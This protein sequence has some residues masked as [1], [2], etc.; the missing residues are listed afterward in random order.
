MKNKQTEKLTPCRG[1]GISM[2]DSENIKK[3]E[4]DL[5]SLN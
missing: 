1:Q 5:L 4:G 2:I 3:G